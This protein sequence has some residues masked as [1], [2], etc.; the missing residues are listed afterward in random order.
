MLIETPRVTHRQKRI[1]A[2]ENLVETSAKLEPK[3]HDKL[4]INGQWVKPTG[5]GTIDVINSTTEEVM[6]RI[7]EGTA[8]DVNAAAAAAKASFES[9]STTSVE[10]RGRY[11]Q[12]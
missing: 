9:W 2:K 10:E 3:V 1:T 5:T 4:Y 7:P 11:L 8:D 6:G 12:L